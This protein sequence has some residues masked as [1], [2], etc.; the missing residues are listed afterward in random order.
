MEAQE[1]S[2]VLRAHSTTQNEKIEEERVRWE[3]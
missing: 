2:S 1:D 3:E